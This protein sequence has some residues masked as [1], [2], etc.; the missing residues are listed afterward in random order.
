MD[1]AIIVVNDEPYSIW[2]VSLSEKNLAYIEGIDVDYFQFLN[3]IYQKSEDSKRASIALRASL[4]HASE[5][6]FTLIGALLQA[7][8]AVYAW[9]SKCSNSELRTILKR[10]TDKDATL[11][12][13]Y[14]LPVLTWEA[15]AEVVFQCYLP[16]TEKQKRTSQ[17]FAAF[18]QRLSY[19][20]CDKDHINEYNSIKHGFR[21]RSGGFSLSMAEE[22]EYGVAPPASEMKLI[23][24]SEYG[25]SFFVLREVGNKGSR[26]LTSRRISINW[27][28]EKVALLLQLVSM[29]IN[30]VT[31]ALKFINGVDAGNCKF[32]R[33]VQDSDFNDP[34]THTPG[35]TSCS[36]NLDVDESQVPNV[37]K[38]E[39]LK[40]LQELKSATNDTAKS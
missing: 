7:P 30:N 15:V 16:G 18:W 29:S 8:F 2:E 9:A 3:E 22:K 35:V 24:K 27:K 37:G 10:I 33:P 31:N 13:S 38:K 34:W 28:L 14:N 5:T 26:A 1:S 11:F 4:H 36:F 17:L 40:K 25:S 21:I 6:L 39:L 19:E 23:G 32:T 12:V 20:F